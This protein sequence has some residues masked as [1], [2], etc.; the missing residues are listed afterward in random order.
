MGG[1]PKDLGPTHWLLSTILPICD[2]DGQS[3]Q[4]H[5]GI[6]SKVRGMGHFVCVCV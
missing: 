5:L 2:G 4:N 1:Q 6:S 3:L